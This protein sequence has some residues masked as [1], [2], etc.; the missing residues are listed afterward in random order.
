MVITR[1]IR[2]TAVIFLTFVFF[3]ALCSESMAQKKIVLRFGDEANPDNP[4]YKANARLTEL[5]NERANGRVVIEHYGS[6]QLGK[7]KA[8]NEACFH[9]IVDLAASSDGNLA[10]YTTALDFQGLPY[11][12]SNIDEEVKFWHSDLFVK[13]VLP[14]I[15]KDIK[16]KF[17]MTFA[18]GGGPRH[19]VHLGKKIV[20]VPD[21]LKGMKIRTT[22]AKTEVAVLKAWGARPTP[23]DWGEVY[24]SLQ[25]GVVDGTYNQYLW[26][27]LPK[28]HEVCKGV[29]ELSANWVLVSTYISLNA[30]N[31][32]S[33]EDQQII[34]KA[35]QEANEYGRKLNGEIDAWAKEQMVKAG[36]RVYVPTAEEEMIWKNKA[37]ETWDQF[38]DAKTSIPPSFLGKVMEVLKK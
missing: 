15:E 36:V 29:T 21:D 20:K 38:V 27:Y 12:F 18:S 16:V 4:L 13:E 24:T 17:L 26:S 14:K 22:G 10:D 19:I 2:C 25:Q 9:G 23:I 32:L 34:S 28:F 3:F 5:V 35:A 33:K 31:K 7:G 1:Y 6:G 11:I 30:W 37:M 8:L